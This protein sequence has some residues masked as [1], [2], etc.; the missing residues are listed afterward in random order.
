MGINR[1]GRGAQASQS[2]FRDAAVRREPRAP[3]IPETCLAES[4]L[5]IGFD[6]FIPLAL[7]DSLPMVERVFGFR[8]AGLPDKRCEDVEVMG[9]AK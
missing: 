1:A 9:L 2:S 3:N 6:A 8:D 4:E 7:D 5:A